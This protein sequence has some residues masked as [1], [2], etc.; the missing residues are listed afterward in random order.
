MGAIALMVRPSCS[1]PFAH[2]SAKQVARGSPLSTAT[3]TRVWI[4]RYSFTISP[5]HLHSLSSRSPRASPETSQSRSGMRRPARA[6]RN[7]APGGA[8]Q[9]RPSAT[10][11]G[12]R[13]CANARP[14]GTAHVQ[15]PTV[16]QGGSGANKPPRWSAERR[17]SY[18]TGRKAPAGAC[19]PTSL[20][21]RRVPLHPSAFRRSASLTFGEG[22]PQ[23]SEDQC[24]ARRTTLAWRQASNDSAIP[25]C[26][27]D[28]TQYSA[29]DNGASSPCGCAAR[30]YVRK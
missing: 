30:P 11:S 17:A 1:C 12:T 5:Q 23:T 26:A 9:N 25:T 4:G 28:A 8:R 7:R 16:R 15:R 13:E 22:K 14:K 18:V 24:L 10:T 21:R 20:A 29:P 3:H 27:D 19:G 2:D 6:A